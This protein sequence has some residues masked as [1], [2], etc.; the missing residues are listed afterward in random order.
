MNQ[1]DRHNRVALDLVRAIVSDTI[2]SG[3]DGADCL[4]LLE[5]V[6]VGAISVLARPGTDE[7]FVDRLASDV[8]RRLGDKR[9]SASRL[10]VCET[11]GTA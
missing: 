8:K 2:A 11:A 3:G 6:C 4:F 7:I 10:A 9:L 5:T 1:A